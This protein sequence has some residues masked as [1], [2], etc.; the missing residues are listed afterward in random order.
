MIWLECQKV[1]GVLHMAQF[2]KNGR[3][4]A[5]LDQLKA[6]DHVEIDDGF[7]CMSAG[8]T[9]VHEGAGGE[10]YIPCSCGRH[11]LSGQHDGDNWLVGIYPMEVK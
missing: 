9:I 6:G 10:L 3:E 11:F 8:T 7:T 1:K 2:D 4:Y 5:K